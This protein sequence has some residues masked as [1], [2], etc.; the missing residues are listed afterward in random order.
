VIFFGARTICRSRLRLGVFL[1]LHAVPYGKCLKG[2]KKAAIHYQP[3]SP[4]IHPNFL[5][6]TAQ[7]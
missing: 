6:R 5:A 1:S 4:S 2:K 7:Q 3:I